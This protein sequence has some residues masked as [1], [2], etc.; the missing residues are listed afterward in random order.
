M[1]DPRDSGLD[2]GQV[3]EQFLDE[4]GKPL[5]V[6]EQRNELGVPQQQET[7]QS[8]HM[9][10]RLVAPEEQQV[11]DAGDPLIVEFRSVLAD[12]LADQAVSW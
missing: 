7:A 5:F 12:E 1:R 3:A 11:A 8:E 10:G 2:D 9:G 6:V 4:V